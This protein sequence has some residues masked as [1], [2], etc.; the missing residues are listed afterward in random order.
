MMLT[1][2]PIIHVMTPLLVMSNAS[3]SFAL[4]SVMRGPLT[5]MS[6]MSSTCTKIVEVDLSG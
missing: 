5:A 6:P 2:M 1:W 3:Q 4:S